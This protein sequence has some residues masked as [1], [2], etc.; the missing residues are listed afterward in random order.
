VVV[1]NLAGSITSDVATLTL[2]NPVVV[3]SLSGGGGTTSNGFTFQASVPVGLTYIILA[4]PDLQSW[5]PIATNVA[6]TASVVFTDPAPASLSKRFY[7]VM[8]P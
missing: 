4:S 8:L 1:T 5:T 7:R 3:L 6:S 2:T